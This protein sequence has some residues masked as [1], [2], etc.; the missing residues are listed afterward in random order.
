M[1]ASTVIKVAI[2][3]PYAEVY[4][5]LADPMNFPRWAGNPG[6][7]IQPLGGGDW[8]VD[9]PRGQ[10]AIRFAPRN[11]F[12]VLDY[13][14]FPV[15]ADGGPVTPVRLLRNEEGC[16]LMLVWFQ[17]DGATDERFKSDAE[18]IASD[19]QRLKSLMESAGQL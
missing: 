10:M 19:L 13:Q 8:L 4:E 17:R 15:E 5:F 14:T 6:S 3:R 7:D 16:E 18:W 11:N 9:L 1:L 12:G 2:E